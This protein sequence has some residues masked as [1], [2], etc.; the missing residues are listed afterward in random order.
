MTALVGIKISRCFVVGAT[1]ASLL[2][3]Q[4]NLYGIESNELTAD[5]NDVGYYADLGWRISAGV[6]NALEAAV[7]LLEADPHVAIEFLVHGKD[8]RLFIDGATRRKPRLVDLSRKLARSG[9]K[10][11]VCDHALSFKGVTLEGF[12]AYFATVGYVPERVTELKRRVYRALHEPP[13]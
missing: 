4:S 9:A 12:P 3:C 2:V 11:L 13:K 5:E 10:I 1:L 8:M 7:K 6:A